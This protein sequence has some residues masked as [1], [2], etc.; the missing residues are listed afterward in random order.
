M[1]IDKYNTDQVFFDKEEM[2]KYRQN[3]LQVSS[4]IINL[5]K[6][7]RKDAQIFKAKPITI[8]QLSS[9]G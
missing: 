7:Q 9:L 4:F 5:N 8:N 3:N 1:V 6:Q 2:K